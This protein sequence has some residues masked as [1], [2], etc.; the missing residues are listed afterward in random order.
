MDLSGT[1][2]TDFGLGRVDVHVHLIGRDVQEKDDDL[3]PAARKDFGVR[4]RD[5]V[6]EQPVADGPSIDEQVLIA[7]MGA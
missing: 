1:T 3:M 5:G 7:R 4:A 6:R 2:E